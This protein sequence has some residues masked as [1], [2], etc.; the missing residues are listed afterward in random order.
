MNARLV[1]ISGPAKGATYFLKDGQN[2]IG[3]A[4]DC[5]II[6]DDAKVSKRHCIINFSQGKAEVSDTGSSNGTFLNGVLVK[7]KRL[8][9][10]DKLSL[11]PFV[12]EVIAG[13][14]VKALEQESGFPELGNASAE[15]N[16]SPQSGKVVARS[17]REKSV[18]KKLFY[19]FDEI[20]PPVVI[21]FN[22][23][24]EWK[25]VA[26]ALFL[27]Y[28]FLYIGLSVYPLLETAKESVLR[29]AERR[30]FYIARQIA[31]LNQEHLANGQEVLLTTDFAE[32][33]PSVSDAMI[34]DLAGRVLAPVSRANESVNNTFIIRHLSLIREGNQKAWR[35]ISKRNEDATKVIV[36]VPIFV[37][38]PKSGLNVPK[39]LVTVTFMLKGI[40]LDAGTIGVV[41]FESLILALLIGVVFLY[42][43]YRLTYNTIERVYDDMDEVLKGNQPSVPKRYKLEPLEK[44]IDSINS[45]LS[46]IPDLKQESDKVV[47]ASDSEQQIIDSLLAP[48]QML[49]LRGSTPMMLLDSEGRIITMNPA[50]EELTGM[51]LESSTQ[52]AVSDVARDEAFS[53]MTSDMMSKA[54][55]LG[56]QGA[57]EDYEFSSGLHRVSCIAIFSLAEKV[58]SFLF[59]I[60]KESEDSN[61]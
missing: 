33:D 17:E 9:V 13:S 45:A 39:A 37:R 52:Q 41:Y 56:M 12:L 23:R 40:T 31:D 15:I 54:I 26:S 44:L 6:L 53:S 46:R 30:A 49:V 34:I 10:N 25:V 38:A 51:H 42:L 11:G 20:F 28:V 58:E 61:G 2:V 59:T 14:A 57:T 47:Q 3:R 7:K 16:S 5:D 21:D 60:E 18:F 29:E 36:T 4:S 50:F 8:Q 48:I 55:A 19:K 43:V 24:H 22:T 27:I 35:L 1:V 32:K